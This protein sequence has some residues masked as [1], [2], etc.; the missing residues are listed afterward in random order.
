MRLLRSLVTCGLLALALSGCVGA[1][2]ASPSATP[3]PLPTSPFGSNEE[4]LAAANAA[5]QRFLDASNSVAMDSSVDIESIRA[6][7]TGQ[8]AENEIASSQAARDRGERRVGPATF[9]SPRYEQLWMTDGKAEVITYACVDL[10]QARVIDM[11]QTDI[12]PPGRDDRVELQ[13]VFISVAPESSELIVERN[14]LWDYDGR[15]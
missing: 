10:T 13:L 15:C 8:A 6:A 11:N 4:A 2:R 9:D 12:T 14:N 5:F 7:A 3:S 1:A